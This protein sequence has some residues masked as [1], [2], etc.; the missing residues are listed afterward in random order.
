VNQ[1]TR[2]VIENELVKQASAIDRE[3]DQKD[4]V[5]DL[6][7]RFLNAVTHH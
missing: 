4:G 7:N 1:G 2:Q 3:S 6:V 5:A